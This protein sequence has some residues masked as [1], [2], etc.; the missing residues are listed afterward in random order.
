MLPRQGEGTEEKLK[1]TRER[2]PRQH[3]DGEPGRASGAGSDLCHRGAKATLAPTKQSQPPVPRCGSIHRG[4]RAQDART[5]AALLC[6]MNLTRAT[7]QSGCAQGAEP[8]GEPVRPRSPSV[9]C[10][11]RGATRARHFVTQFTPSSR[12][13]AQGP[14]PAHCRSHTGSPGQRGLEPTGAKCC[15]SREPCF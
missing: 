6:M 2:T 12:K 15:L 8:R 3:E 4:L 10:L 9:P 1:Q 11:L 13:R 14:G 5:V 7:L